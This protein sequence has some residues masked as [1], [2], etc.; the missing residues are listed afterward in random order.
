MGR[1][2]EEWV[3]ETVEAMRV[4]DYCQTLAVL[5]ATLLILI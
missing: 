5:L 4:L 3:E 2:I 1:T